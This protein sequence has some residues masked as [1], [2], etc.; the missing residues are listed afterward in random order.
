MQVEKK[1]SRSIA[2]IVGLTAAGGRV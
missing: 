2:G 1:T